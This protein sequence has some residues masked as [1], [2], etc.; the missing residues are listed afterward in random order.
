ML[1][2][3]TGEM[4]RGQ[5]WRRET[6]KTR[7]H[8]ACVF[9]CVLFVCFFFFLQRLGDAAEPHHDANGAVRGR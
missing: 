3:M 6:G 7:F 4:R 5:V 8:P 1:L 2:H 9:T